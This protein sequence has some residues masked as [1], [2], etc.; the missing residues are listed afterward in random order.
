MAESV[1]QV[2]SIMQSGNLTTKEVAEDLN[3]RF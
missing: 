3:H 1:L 2:F